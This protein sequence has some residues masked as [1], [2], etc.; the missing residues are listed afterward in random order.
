MTVSGLPSVTVS[1]S[2]MGKLYSGIS[3]RI[4]LTASV[5]RVSIGIFEYP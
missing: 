4:E 3:S 5:L 2:K 1:K